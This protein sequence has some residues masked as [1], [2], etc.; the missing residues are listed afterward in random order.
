MKGAVWS[1]RRGSIVVQVRTVI[2][3]EFPCGGASGGWGDDGILA[4]GDRAAYFVHSHGKME[5]DGD[6]AKRYMTLGGM[7]V[8]TEGQDESRKRYDE[9]S[10]LV[11]S[12]NS[13][14]ADAQG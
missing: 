10:G 11:V 7:E 12:V 14:V 2:P 1:I 4:F 13:E 8:I 3:F 5:V 9:V 6:G